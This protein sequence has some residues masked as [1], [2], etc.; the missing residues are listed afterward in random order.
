MYTNNYL[1]YS[2]LSRFN[3]TMSFEGVHKSYENCNSYNFKQSEI[4]I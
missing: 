2:Y 4:P 3:Y 1:F